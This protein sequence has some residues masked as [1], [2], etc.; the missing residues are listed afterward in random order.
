MFRSIGSAELI[1]LLVLLL[2]SSIVTVIPLCRITERAGFSGWWGLLNLVPFGSF[3][4]AYFLAF[5]KW[6][7]DVS[8]G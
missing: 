8:Q 4:W 2:G 3:V 7:R 5:T 1:V 6:P